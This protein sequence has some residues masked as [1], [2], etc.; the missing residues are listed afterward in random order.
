[1]AVGASAAS[2]SERSFRR[3]RTSKK[4]H[5]AP[6]TMAPIS[7]QAHAGRP[8]DSVVVVGAGVVTVLLWTTAFV[9]VGSVTVFVFA[10][11]VTVFVCLT[12]FVCVTVFVLVG[13]VTV[14]VGVVGGAV[15]VDFVCAEAFAVW[16]L[17]G[18]ASLLVFVVVV[19]AVL[20]V[21]AADSDLSPVA[22][23]LTLLATLAAPPEPQAT[24]PKRDRPTVPTSR[25]KPA[26]VLFEARQRHPAAP[27]SVPALSR[28]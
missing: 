11:V 23:P 1:M 20:L 2:G 9:C 26:A 19:G 8:P 28:A 3:R 14:V 4:A 24:K 27:P 25:A 13:S 5:T 6:T 16:L 22:V 7:N 21:P 17:G 18:F 12:V 10:G 15:V